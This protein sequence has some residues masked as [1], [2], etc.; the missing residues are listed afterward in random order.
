ML[1]L[2]ILL[3]VVSGALTTMAGLGGVLLVLA[4][5]LVGGPQAAR[6]LRRR[7]RC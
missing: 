3:G 7:R 4:L 5:S 6:W 1:G 2:L